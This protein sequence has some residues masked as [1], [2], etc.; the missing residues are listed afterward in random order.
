MRRLIARK[1]KIGERRMIQM[2]LDV[3]REDVLRGRYQED[4]METSDVPEILLLILN[5]VQLL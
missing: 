3:L 1:W 5:V 2:Y 4:W